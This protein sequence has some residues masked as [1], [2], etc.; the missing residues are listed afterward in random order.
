MFKI[1]DDAHDESFREFETREEAVRELH[2]LA[3]LPWDQLPN[4]AP[5]T[6]WRNCGRRYELVEFEVDGTFHRELRRTLSLR[7]LPKDRSGPNISNRL[8]YN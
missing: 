5:C 6:N 4:L 2:N 8:P 7:Y 3:T 1:E